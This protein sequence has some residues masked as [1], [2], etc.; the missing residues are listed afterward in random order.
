MTTPFDQ[1]TFEAGFATARG[2]FLAQ[3]ATTG[4]LV[5]MAIIAL[6]V[7]VALLAAPRV[8]GW[9]RTWH[10]RFDSDSRLGQKTNVV[11]RRLTIALIPLIVPILMLPL[12]AAALATA[13][14]AGWPAQ[15][16]NLATSLLGAWVVIR[17]TSSVLRDRMRERLIAGVVWVLAA[18]N[19]FG[20]LGDT[21]DTLGRISFTIGSL[22]LSPITIVTGLVWLA[23]LLWLASWSARQIEDRLLSISG[24]AASTQV[25]F[26]RLIKVMLII[27]AVFIALGTIGI[28]LTALAVFT[29]AL[30]VGIGFGLQAIFNNFVAGLILLSERSLKVGDFVDLDHG[31]LAGTVR[32][33]SVRNTI[34]TTPDNIDVA[35]PNS[36]F[37]N[38]RVTNWT[39]LDAHARIHVPFGVAYGIDVETVR[40]VVF[41]AAEQVPF[42]LQ[43]DDNRKLLLWLVKFGEYRL[44]FEL[45]VWLT[46]EGIHRPAGAR[47]A[48]CLAI[49]NALRKHGIEMPFPQRDLHIK[50]AIPLHVDRGDPL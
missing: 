15:H 41:E 6:A 48:Y 29:G 43:G 39:M 3:V 25:L 35:V 28:D 33:I 4:A 26:A 1:P 21:F 17:L 23:G 49:Y 22:H 27:G 18:L 36:E 46:T 14:T 32:K 24:L 37:V 2:W 50:S 44:E 47:A 10:R 8:R 40:A 13:R 12:L 42:T 19:I 5:Q 30:G 20:L 16:L 31:H 9:I 11:V 38:G 34:I 45:V 7:I